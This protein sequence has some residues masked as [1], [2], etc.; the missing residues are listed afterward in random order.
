MKVRAFAQVYM[1]KTVKASGLAKL[2]YRADW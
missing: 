2:A 1:Q